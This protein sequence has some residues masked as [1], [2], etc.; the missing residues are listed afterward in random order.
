MCVLCNRS[1]CILISFVL[2]LVCAREP[3]EIKTSDSSPS[4]SDDVSESDLG[5]SSWF[6]LVQLILFALTLL[7]VLCNQALNLTGAC[8]SDIPTKCS[9]MVIVI[10]HRNTYI[11]CAFSCASAGLAF[12]GCPARDAE[13][14]EERK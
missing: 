11:L 4:D 10:A 3:S 7:V 13:A 9:K 12:D 5:K 8:P 1:F 6:S 14:N 2:P